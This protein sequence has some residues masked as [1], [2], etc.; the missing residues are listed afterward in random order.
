VL[1]SVVL[2]FIASA[3]ASGPA[4]AALTE[5]VTGTLGA[6]AQVIVRSYD[7]APPG[8]DQ[9]EAAA[10]AQGAAAAARLVWDRPGGSRAALD[11]YLAQNDMT[12]HRV[13]DFEPQ[14]QPVD[15]GR[16]IG[17]V[18][19]SLLLAEAPEP[20]P[21]EPEPLRPDEEPSEVVEPAVVPAGPWALEGFALG[22]LALGGAGAGIG[23]GLAARFHLQPP[24]GLRLGLHARGGSVA[25]AQASSLAIALSA[26]G[27]RSL[28]RSADWRSWDLAARAEML[29]MYEALTHFS[30]DDPA[31][32]RKGR[33]LPGGAALLEAQWQIAPAAALH[34]AGGME[35]AFG[36]TR[37][38]VRGNQVAQLAPIRAVLEAGFRARF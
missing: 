20:P 19:A 17:L 15:R 37:I 13:L 11:V 4:V 5:A 7:G 18:L 21:R 30:A 14:D 1:A 31:P 2:V 35:G 26:G 12:A 27:F 38:V 34:L 8:D 3:D 25:V 22:G 16:A 29:L 23:G 32:V 9:M 36:V 28:R 6:G 24:W 33:L 10:R